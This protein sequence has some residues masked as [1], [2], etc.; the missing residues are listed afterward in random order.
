MHLR[1]GA[2]PVQDADGLVTL[3]DADKQSI[4]QALVSTSPNQPRRRNLQR[5]DSR[6]APLIVRDAASDPRFN[7]SVLVRGPPNIRFYAG[8]PL[9]VRPVSI[10]AAF[11]S[12]TVR[13]ATSASKS[14][15]ACPARGP[16]GE[17]DSRLA[18]GAQG[19]MPA[20]SAWR[21]LPAWPKSAASNLAVR[22][23]S[24]LGRT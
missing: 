14:K 7:T 21:R 2:Q 18:R 13:H 1:T 11:A 16:H 22:R 20:R 15:A 19:S 12:S 24:I 3:I 6:N 9:Q 4:W 5:D 8:A 23:T 10:S 17:R